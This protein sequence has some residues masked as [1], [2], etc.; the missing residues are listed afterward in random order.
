MSY[1]WFR[2]AALLTALVLTVSMIPHAR[3]EEVTD[4]LLVAPPEAVEEPAVSEELTEGEEP[5]ASEEAAEGEEPAVPEEPEVAEPVWEPVGECSEGMIRITDGTI[6]GYAGTDG[7]ILIEPQF[8]AA[9]EFY[10]GIAQVTREGKAG[11]LRWD[12]TFL[13]EPEYDQLTGVGFGVYLGKRGDS[14]ELLSV[15]AIPTEAGATHQLRSDLASATVFEGTTVQQIILQ[16]RNGDSSWIPVNTLPQVLQD[17]RAPGWQFPLST[18]RQTVFSD[19]AED[20]W[21]ARWVKIA[22]NVGMMKGAG[23]GTFEPMRTL[24]VAETLH[25][26]ACL[27][28][29]AIQDDFHLR[30][31]SGATWYSSSVVYCEASGIIKPGAF[32]PEDYGRPVTRAEM[33]EILGATTAVRGM[34][35]IN[36]IN[37]VERAIPDVSW[38]DPGAD[39]IHKMYA[40][41]ILNGTDGKLSFCP[42]KPLTR[43]EAAA[44]ISRIARPEQRL[45][46]WPT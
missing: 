45:T 10:L 35:Q 32:G 27:E 4:E 8:D 42:E 41:G 44:I 37:R 34:E 26:A 39:A 20:T 36:N 13:L 33:A 16:D 23:D 31:N 43:A 7:S 14:W 22:Y 38:N 28:S 40:K 18:S 24:T 11:L 3:A 21:Y 6:W 17:Y 30:S 5:V 46:L 25:L 2:S 29:R 1:K 12:G 15:T 9:E 19:V